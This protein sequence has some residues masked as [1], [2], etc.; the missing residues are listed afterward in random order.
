MLTSV[1]CFGDSR[2]ARPVLE[3]LRKPGA[4]VRKVDSNVHWFA[5]VRV[6]LETMCAASGKIALFVRLGWL[7]PAKRVDGSS[8]L[9]CNSELIN[10][11]CLL[12]FDK[13]CIICWKAHAIIITSCFSNN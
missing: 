13:I 2:A 8:D 1:G 3:L 4:V 5:H 12:L 10:I 11:L 9:N 6:E 7:A